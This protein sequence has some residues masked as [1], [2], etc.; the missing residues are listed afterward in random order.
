MRAQVLPRCGDYRDEIEVVKVW[1]GFEFWVKIVAVNIGLI[2]VGSR[3]V[4]VDV[5][6]KIYND[7]C[8]GF[9]FKFN[10]LSKIL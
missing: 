7:F 8:L 10:A 2:V 6:R 4:H 1:V 3:L 5:K 9:C